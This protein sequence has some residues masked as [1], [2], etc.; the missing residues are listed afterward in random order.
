PARNTAKTLKRTAA[1]AGFSFMTKE[2]RSIYS[3]SQRIT[4]RN[5]RKAPASVGI[6]D[7]V[8][9]STD[10]RLKVNVIAPTGLGVAA[11]PTSPSSEGSYEDKEKE[12][13]WK[14]L[15]KGLKARWAPLEAG[16]EDRKTPHRGSGVD[17]AYCAG[18]FVNRYN[19]LSPPH[20]RLRSIPM[21]SPAAFWS[22]IAL[23]LFFIYRRTYAPSSRARVATSHGH[24]S[25]I[26]INSS[27][28]G[29]V[30]TPS[31]TSLTRSARL[32]PE[33]LDHI[34][35][36]YIASLVNDLRCGT[37]RDYR[38]RKKRL[39]QDILV[40]AVG[41]KQFYRVMLW[42]LGKMWASCGLGLCSRER[43][44]AADNPARSVWIITAKQGCL[45]LDTDLGLYIILEI[46]SINY[47]DGVQWSKEQQRFRRFRCIS[48]YP[49]SLR[50]LEIL[51]SHT[52]EEEVIRLV[53]DC[54]PGLTEL[55]LVRCT[56]FNDPKCWYWRVHTNN[57]DHDYMQSYDPAAVVDYANRM[58]LLLRGLPRLE[59][60]HIGHYL[61][62]INAVFTHRLEQAHKRYHPIIDTTSHVDGVRVV[63]NVRL[64]ANADGGPPIDWR[65]ARL[66]DRELWANSCPQ[67]EREFKKPIERAERLAAGI[68]AAHFEFLKHVSFV[69]FLS[70][71]RIDPSSWLVGR[72]WRG[73][74][75]Y[76]RTEDPNRPRSRIMQEMVQEGNRWEP[77]QVAQ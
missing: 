2:K 26:D 34:F 68:L 32:P 70:D 30:P 31:P 27:L 3:Q 51:R 65:S 38:V 41:S 40:V 76:V 75:L 58:A 12:H 29:S 11:A 9:V 60:I 45:P 24:D 67:C 49:R 53:S 28:I 48:A 64:G 61:I 47:H 25:P 59:S 15:R 71:R 14:I 8:P 44:Y 5:S 17:L 72:Q 54:C 57:Q 66:A 36:F 73:P 21:F 19:L 56:M 10:E 69:N 77:P 42:S 1:Q 62:S 55:R 46:A 74:D 18:A 35:S 6:L 33:A 37:V 7:H 43:Y 52:P 4:I 20:H 39:M 16:G 23:A 63:S 22:S 13:P 50:Q